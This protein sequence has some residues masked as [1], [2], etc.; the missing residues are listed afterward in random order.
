MQ[1]QFVLK[2]QKVYDNF[3]RTLFVREIY[4]GSHVL[5]EIRCNKLGGALR[6]RN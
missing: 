2:F 5:V 4:G 3:I 1:C 6:L